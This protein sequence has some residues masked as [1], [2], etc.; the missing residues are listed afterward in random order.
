MVCT[1]W[2]MQQL[3]SPI[4]QCPIMKDSP[5]SLGQQLSR[6][7]NG[8]LGLSVEKKRKKR[9]RKRKRRFPS[10]GTSVPSFRDGRR[11]RYS[12]GILTPY[13]KGYS[14]FSVV[15]S[16]SYPLKDCLNV[17]L[18]ERFSP[19]FLLLKLSPDRNSPVGNGRVYSDGGRVLFAR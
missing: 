2:P 10:S 19:V 5:R 11:V 6:K 15:P 12:K 13:D 17:R 14:L 8:G 3:L 18:G 9:R 16:L 1:L 7:E 4:R